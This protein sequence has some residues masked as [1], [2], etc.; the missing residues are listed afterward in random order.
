MVVSSITS[1]PLFP[2]GKG[3]WYPL[4]LKVM[5]KRKIFT[6]AG[7]GTHALVLIDPL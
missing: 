4:D 3:L 6:P 7:N 1:L 2:D 5:E